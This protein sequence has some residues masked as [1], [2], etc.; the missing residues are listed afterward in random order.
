MP[1]TPRLASGWSS[2]SAPRSAGRPPRAAS[3]GTRPTCSCRPSRARP[4]SASPCRPASTWRW[5]SAKYLYGLPDG[6]VP[7]AFNFNG[8]VHYRG[9]DGRLQLSLV[10]WSCSAEFRFPVSTWRELMEHYYPRT[11]WVPVH[12]ANAAGASAREGPAR[13]ADARR[14][15]WRS[16]SRRARERS[17]TLVDSLLY[18]GYAL[19]PYTPGATKNA[20]PTPFGIVY[21]PAYAEA[22]DTTY[23]HLELQCVVEGEGELSAEVRFLAPSGERHRAEAQRLDGQRRVSRPPACRFALRIGR[24]PAGGQPPARLLPRRERHRGAD[25]GS[26]RAAAIERSLISAHPIVSVRRRALHL[27]ARGAL[28]QR[29]HLARARLA[30]GRRDARRRDR[31]ARPSADRPREPGQPVRQH[32]DRG[33]ARPARTGAERRRAGRDRAAGPGGAGDD[34]ARAAP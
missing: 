4:R 27:S 23:D 25:P 22:L 19:Y 18:E 15:R 21:P 1:T 28:R 6:E 14:L 17:R 16:C 7:L 30:P 10:P 32:R 33:G 29:Q 20:T 11:G 34:R 12:E 26:N 9:D 31:A 3:S 5:P 24:D 2:C 13:A 8:T